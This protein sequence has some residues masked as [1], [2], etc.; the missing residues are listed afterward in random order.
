MAASWLY[1]I[2]LPWLFARLG[3][4]LRAGATPVFVDVREDDFCMDAGQVEAAITPRTRAIMPVHLYGLMADMEPLEFR[5]RSHP[6]LAIECHGLTLWDL[7]R[8]FPV[9]SFGGHSGAEPDTPC[10]ARHLGQLAS[11]Y[12]QKILC[13]YAR[14]TTSPWRGSR[15][16]W[17]RPS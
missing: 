3:W 9:G 14:S 15:P 4:T 8:E 13:A 7:D 17:R 6:G 16:S 1:L 11:A 5:Q 10:R 2:L 12:A